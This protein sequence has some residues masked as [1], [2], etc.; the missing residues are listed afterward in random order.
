MCSEQHFENSQRCLSLPL[1]SDG[2][3]PLL[4]PE[5]LLGFHEEQME[6]AAGTQLRQNFQMRV[7][8]CVNV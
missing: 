1:K 6:G 8:M 2:M 4:H 5:L 3:V 7:Q